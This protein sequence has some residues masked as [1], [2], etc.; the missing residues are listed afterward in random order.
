MGIQRYLPTGTGY[1]ALSNLLEQEHFY[2]WITLVIEAYQEGDL[3]C[4][5]SFSV[6]TLHSASC[7]SFQN[8]S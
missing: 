2:M 3:S 4:C 6:E 8:G 7:T 5:T 1:M